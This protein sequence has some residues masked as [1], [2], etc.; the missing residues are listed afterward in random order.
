MFFFWFSYWWGYL[1][2]VGLSM[3]KHWVIRHNGKS[4]WINFVL[5][6]INNASNEEN[7]R[8]SHLQFWEIIRPGVDITFRSKGDTV[9]LLNG[10]KA[11]H[12]SNEF[13]RE[14]DKYSDDP[15]KISFQNRK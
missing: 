4:T 9:T 14:A 13:L 7:C 11:H 12:I 5:F 10:L 3:I 6:F 8:F 15:A 1:Y 2:D